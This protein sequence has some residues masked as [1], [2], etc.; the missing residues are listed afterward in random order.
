MFL[1]DGLSSHLF[2]MEYFLFLKYSAIENGKESGLM[3]KRIQ[4]VKI[5][6]LEGGRNAPLF[7]IK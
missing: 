7:F 2:F 5:L 3:K 4:V 1:L 6:C